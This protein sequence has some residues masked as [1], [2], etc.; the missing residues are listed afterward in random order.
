VD[1][2]GHVEWIRRFRVAR[3]RRQD[4][5]DP[6]WE[7]G[8]CLDAAVW[9][10]V[11]RFQVGEDGD[12]AHLIGKADAAG[13]GDYAEAVRL[14]VAE[15]QNHARLLARLLA[16]G[17][18]PTLAGHWSDSAFVRL[19]RLLDLR[20]ELLV[21]MLAE[22]VALRYYRALRDGSGDALTSQVAARILA[23]EQRHVPFH[24][25]RLHAS[26]NELPRPLRR[27]VLAGWRVML[28][29]ACLVVVVDHGAALRRLGVRRLRFVTDVMRSSGT[30]VRAI[31][32]APRRTP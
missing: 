2:G 8:A 31:L 12:G 22:V 13:D 3:Q 15:E 28:L 4:E 16:A 29:G 17:D 18:M 30:V 23:D 25:E 21:L 27:P 5:G 10:S 1:G 7:K 9:A 14:F 19:R 26:L 11:Q 20:T 6:P 24:C 32:G